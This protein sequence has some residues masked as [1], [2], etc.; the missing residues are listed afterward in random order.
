M[1]S[2]P[3]PT[4]CDHLQPLLNHL[5]ASGAKITFAGQAWSRNCRMWV[6]FDRILDLP[7]LEKQFPLPPCVSRHSHRG[8]HEGS[9][10]GLV[11]HE[12]HDALIGP[13]Q[14]SP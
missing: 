5:L 2:P 12:H 3:T 1:S 7:A 13:Y 4:V 10:T 6:Y 8:T 9:E 14:E 11:C